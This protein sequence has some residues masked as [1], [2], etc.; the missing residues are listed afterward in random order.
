MEKPA[1]IT[2]GMH[3]DHRGT[4]SFIN[5][6]HLND[7]KR[8]YAIEPAAPSVVRAWQGHKEEQKW[9]Y[10][11]AGSFKVVV[12]KIDDWNTP[13]AQPDIFQFDLSAS[14][15]EILRIPG[16]YAN[17]FMAM[18]ENSKIIIFSDFTV[19]QSM[20]DEHRFDQDLWFDWKSLTK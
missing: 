3:H 11:V 13:S 6:F 10:A 5:D 19:Q 17:G 4:I 20:N 2:G 18:E 15:P 16:G 1:F 9:F 7:V 12:V 14:N 8:L